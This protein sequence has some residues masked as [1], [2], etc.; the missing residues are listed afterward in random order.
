VNLIHENYFQENL[1]IHISRELV[2]RKRLA[3]QIRAIKLVPLSITVRN[4][5]PVGIFTL[6]T[7]IL[8]V[9]PRES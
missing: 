1:D 9:I 7:L 2:A 4:M 6:G 5:L 3:V 8:T